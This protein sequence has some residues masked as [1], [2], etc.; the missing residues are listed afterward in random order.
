MRLRFGLFLLVG[1]L[2]FIGLIA[3]AKSAGKSRN[4]EDR[5]DLE[6]ERMGMAE[7]GENEE[8]T[9]S[10]ESSE[11]VENDSCQ[12]SKNKAFKRKTFRFAI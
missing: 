5:F 8:I 2:L 3:I 9:D 11:S 1:L 6:L 7:S 10:C 12:Q 4:R